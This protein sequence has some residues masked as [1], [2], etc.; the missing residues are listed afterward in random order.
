MQYKAEY[1]RKG[2]N[3]FPPNY[4]ALAG[5]LQSITAEF[6]DDTPLK[7]VEK[8]AKEATPEGFEFIRVTAL[9]EPK[10]PRK[11][12]KVTSA[13]KKKKEL[14]PRGARIIMRR[15]LDEKF[16]DF[17]SSLREFS[18]RTGISLSLYFVCP[19]DIDCGMTKEDAT[20]PLTEAFLPKNE[21]IR[22]HHVKGLICLH[23]HDCG[24]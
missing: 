24:Y 11:R 12:S 17:K 7:E 2:L 21:T 23:C 19:I 10:A 13:V 22:R 8:M 3:P 20:H 16:A 9:K 1:R 14:T 15:E 18:E 6:P 5:S 4:Q